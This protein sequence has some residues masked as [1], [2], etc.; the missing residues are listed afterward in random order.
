[1]KKAWCAIRDQPVYRRHAFVHGLARAGFKIED[2]LLN[3]RPGDA[4]VI[5]NRY[6]HWHDMAS[7][8][9]RAGGIVIVAEN[10]YLGN[11]R[12]N[13]TRYAIARDGHNGSGMWYIGGSERWDSLGLK[14][15]PWRDDGEHILVCPNRS[16]GRPDFIMPPTWVESVTARLKAIT[17]RPV[18]VRPHP[19]NNVPKR[20]L[21]EDLKNAWAV[22]IWSSSAGCEALLS[23]IPVFCTAP[24]WVAMDG[25]CSGGLEEINKPVLPDRSVAMRKLAWAQWDIQEIENGEPFSYLCN[26]APALA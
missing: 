23:G 6:S 14:L 3:P 13:R 16:F 17:K 21:S 10:G 15:A 25:A 12:N 19:G 11:D 7:R 18:V 2:G 5:W 26:N 22:V 24:Y 4:L 9:E 1:M 8:F 20:P